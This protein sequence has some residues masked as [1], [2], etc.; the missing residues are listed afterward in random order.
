MSFRTVSDSA[1]SYRS[2]GLPTMHGNTARGKLSPANPHLT[3]PVPLSHTTTFSRATSMVAAIASRPEPTV[4]VRSPRAGDGG[5][6]GASF[7]VVSKIWKSWHWIPGWRETRNIALSPLTPILARIMPESLARRDPCR[8]GSPARFLGFVAL[9]LF[10]L[11]SVRQMAETSGASRVP[12][13][14]DVLSPTDD[15]A[16]RGR[17]LDVDAA[18]RPRVDP[19]SPPPASPPPL[20]DAAWTRRWEKTFGESEMGVGPRDDDDD[21]PAEAAEPTA[22]P[23]SASATPP[24]PP[25]LSR[26][27]PERR[28]PAIGG[29]YHVETGHIVDDEGQV[30]GHSHGAEPRQHLDDPDVT[31]VVELNADGSTTTTTKDSKRSV[32]SSNA[33]VPESSNALVPESSNALV[34]ESSNALVPESTAL[35]AESTQSTALAALPPSP[36]APPP[37]APPAP[38]AGSSTGISVPGVGEVVPLRGVDASCRGEASLDLDGPA[39]RWGMDHRVASAGECCEACKAHAREHADEPPERRCNS[40]VFCPE[41]A[42]WAPDIWNH[43]LGECW[44]KVQEDPDRPKVNFRG[45]YPPEFRAHHSTAPTHVAWQAGVIA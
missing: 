21:R 3:N 33:L 42:C 13:R 15:D 5:G 28:V 43:T 6:E 29:G 4:L 44:L 10:G 12:S 11:L 23:S 8:A 32:E 19:G 20:D 27:H 45:A 25:R 34:P 41:P 7:V 24:P 36:P 17:L 22:E 39:V 2:V 1:S 35:V 9:M 30:I 40:W 31:T 37:H 38:S 14:R 26:P 16:G 18:T